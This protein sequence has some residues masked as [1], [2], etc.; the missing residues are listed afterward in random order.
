VGKIKV[1]REA[2]RS[3]SQINDLQPGKAKFYRQTSVRPR[4]FN[5]FE[6]GTTP[7]LHGRV[8]ILQ[9]RCSPS[10]GTSCS[11]LGGRRPRVAWGS[12]GRC[13]R[14]KTRTTSPGIGPPERGG[15]SGLSVPREAAEHCGE[16]AYCRGSGGVFFCL[17]TLGNTPLRGG[18]HPC[19]PG[20]RPPDV[21]RKRG[22]KM[23]QEPLASERMGAIPGA[24]TWA[25]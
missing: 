1:S 11:A 21:P 24:T 2:P 22:R 15:T 23:W 3:P 25:C 17:P 4:A 12:T 13:V 8:V 14:E 19:G 16:G 20:V 7:L 10:R 5:G 18:L 6:P 9:G